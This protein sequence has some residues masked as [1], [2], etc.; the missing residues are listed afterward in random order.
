M[1]FQLTIILCFGLITAQ[2]I[3]N[4]LGGTGAGD[5]YDVT[6][7]GGSVLMRL[8][9]DNGFVLNGSFARYPHKPKSIIPIV[10]EMNETSD[11]YFVFILNCYIILTQSYIFLT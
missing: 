9:G 3:T 1:R 2:D 8:Q 6:D 10:G 4:K 11:L 7:S 5:T